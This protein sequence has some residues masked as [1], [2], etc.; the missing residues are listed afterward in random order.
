MLGPIGA[1]LAPGLFDLLIGHVPGAIGSLSAPLLLLG[2]VLLLKRRAARWQ[3]P[4]VYL[5]TF[6]VLSFVFGGLPGGQGWFAGGPGFNSSPVA[7]SWRLLRRDRSRHVAADEV[8]CSTTPPVWACPTFFTRFFGS[9][10]DGVAV[11]ILLGTARCRSS[12]AL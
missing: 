6:A 9:L 2:A 11:A 3:V 1:P 12:T 7:D 4:V 5:A 8:W 10:G